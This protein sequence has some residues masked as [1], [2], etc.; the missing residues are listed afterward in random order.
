MNEPT[1]KPRCERCGGPIEEGFATATGLIPTPLSDP[2]LVF[3]VPG[4]KTSPNPL[5]ALQQ[6]LEQAPA[7]RAYLLRGRRC[8]ECG[9]VELFATE[10]TPWVP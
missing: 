6:G 1:S 8:T 3:V 7:N 10:T 5:Q 2:R 9:A 4:E